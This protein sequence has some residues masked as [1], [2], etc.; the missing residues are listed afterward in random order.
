[1]NQAQLKTF[2]NYVKKWRD[3]FGLMSWEISV[4][5]DEFDIDIVARTDF[6]VNNRFALIRFNNDYTDNLSNDNLNRTALHEVLEIL[7]ATMRRM[8]E[9]QFAFNVV[10]RCVHKLIRTFENVLLK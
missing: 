5:R 1:L 7:F 6:D 3:T 8:S 10:D 2:T 4:E 9:Q